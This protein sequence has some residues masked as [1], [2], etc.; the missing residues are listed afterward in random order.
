MGSDIITTCGFGD[1]VCVYNN[2]TTWII[3]TINHYIIPFFGFFISIV[4]LFN[5][6]IQYFVVKMEFI[7]NLFIPIWILLDT[8]RA[9]IFDILNALFGANAYASTTVTLIILC[10]SYSLVVKV[11]NSLADGAIFGWQLPKLPERK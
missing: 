4:N 2:F 8:V 10:C 5:G 6:I 9:V 3:E 7:G 11:Y 1:I